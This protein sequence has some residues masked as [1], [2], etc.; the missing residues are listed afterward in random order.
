MTADQQIQTERASARN[1]LLQTA[2]RSAHYEENQI[3]RKRTQLFPKESTTYLISKSQFQA[4][5]NPIQ[6]KLK[7]KNANFKPIQN[8][9]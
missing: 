6:A 3:F 1:P 2:P 4:N 7:P 8:P 5:L 9:I